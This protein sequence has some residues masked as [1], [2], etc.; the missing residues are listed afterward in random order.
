MTRTIRPTVLR[1]LARSALALLMIAAL[2]GGCGLT[3]LVRAQ[4]AQE[5]K[6]E[7]KLRER[8]EKL[9]KKEEDRKKDEGKVRSKEAKRY[10]TLREFAEDQYASDTD[11]H[12]E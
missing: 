2:V 7:K 3:A 9:Q 5:S 10:N 1:R 11:F 4:D 6:D 12:D 8:Q